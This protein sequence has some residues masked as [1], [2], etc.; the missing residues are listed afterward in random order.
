M[1]FGIVYR[2]IRG[3]IRKIIF[4]IALIAVIIWAVFFKDSDIQ[5]GKAVNWIGGLLSNKVEIS[6][7]PEKTQ[8]TFVIT[9]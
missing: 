2:L 8:E 3:I 5:W 4:T 7:T 6:V 9:I 1:I